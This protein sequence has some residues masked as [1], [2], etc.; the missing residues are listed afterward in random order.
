V[1][2]IP[3]A[4]I[5]VAGTSKVKASTS[6]VRTRGQSNSTPADL[7]KAMENMTIKDQEIEKLTQKLIKS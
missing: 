5:L 1:Q 3:L 2:A 7:A 4:V 6:I